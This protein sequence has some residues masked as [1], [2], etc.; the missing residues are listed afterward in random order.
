[1]DSVLFSICI[2]K[3]S[4]T[5]VSPYRMV[6]NKDAILPFEYADRSNN[7]TH[8]HELNKSCD[9]IQSS[10]FSDDLDPISKLLQKLEKQRKNSFQGVAKNILWAQKHQAKWYNIRNGAGEPFE[11]GTKVLK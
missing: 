11:I 6:Y 9:D 7:L 2:S 5:G 4:S 10:E 8:D 3:H 1:M